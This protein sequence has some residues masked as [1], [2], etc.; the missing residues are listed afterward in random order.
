MTSS[1]ESISTNSQ[2]WVGIEL[3]GIDTT[4]FEEITSENADKFRR[5]VEKE[6]NENL[7]LNLNSNQN[8]NLNE[9]Q[10]ENQNENRNENQNENR[11]EN[12][13]ENQ[14]ENRN[15]NDLDG[16][17]D[18]NFEEEYTDFYYFN[19][20][21]SSKKKSQN[22]SLSQSIFNLANTII[23]AGS[24]SIPF[25]FKASGAILGT[26]LLVFSGL[27]AVYSMYLLAQ[28]SEFS[29][30]FGYSELAKKAYKKVGSKFVVFCVFL[31]TLGASAGYFCF[32]GDLSSSIMGHYLDTKKTFLK[33]RRFL[34]LV[35]V[36]LVCFPLTFFDNIVKLSLTSLIS[37]L[38]VF[39]VGIQTVIKSSIY[40]HKNGINHQKI[41]YFNLK[42][43]LFLAI[44]IFS[45][46][47]ICQINFFPILDRLAN[48]T[49]KRKR[50]VILD[51]VGSSAF[52]YF[53]IGLFGYLNFYDETQGNVLL[54]YGNDPA[55]IIAKFAMLITIIFSTPII[56]FACKI[57][58]YQLFFSEQH[59][60]KWKKI[61]SIL[62]PFFIALFIGIFVPDVVPIFGF[63]GA[64]SGNIIVYLLPALFF[65]KLRHDIIYKHVP[66]GDDSNE[67][68][69][70]NGK[71]A[72]KDEGFDD[73][74]HE[75]KKS[76]SSI[77]T[78]N[79]TTNS[80]ENLVLN[81]KTKE[82]EIVPT[83]METLF[84]SR[85]NFIISIG[86][87]LLILYSVVSTVF[88]VRQ[89]LIELKKSF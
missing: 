69:E 84:L 86:P 38:A 58:F 27:L 45:I 3:S 74:N 39:Y 47:F 59:P 11:N 12:Q 81:Q 51:S 29:N 49:K 17:K 50:F 44:P 41:V 2:N 79:E 73:Q 61:I 54:N 37:L 36:V 66:I 34:I 62:I 68:E 24:L 32:I 6:E 76:S 57:S 70:N 67:I 56:F 19:K 64:L 26:L 71:N 40:L 14:N 46:S 82:D 25:A 89:S 22:G 52:F 77:S 4:D 72:M 80:N 7:N 21:F 8:L 63:T 42:S 55:S 88:C 33:D 75:R 31:L 83:F 53:F 5:M 30:V 60:R 48:P 15:E 10:N 23:G 87:I 35:V 1:T 9:N 28:I 13:N 85:N 65:L 20:K 18:I 43:D 16:F 78:F